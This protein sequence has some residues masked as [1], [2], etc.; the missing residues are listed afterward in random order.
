MD[1]AD[2]KKSETV[3]ILG[4]GKSAYERRVDIDKYLRGDVWTLNTGYRY[5]SHILPHITAWFELHRYDY[6]IKEMAEQQDPKRFETLRDYDVPVFVSETL[7]TITK[8][9]AYPYED[10]FKDLETNVFNGS[11]ALMAMLAIHLGY[12]EICAYGI[13]QLDNQHIDQRGAWAFV[14]GIAHARGIKITGTANLFL[15]VED[16]DEGLRGIRETWGEILV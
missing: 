14:L 3:T 6:L 7:P 4:F 9:I 13:D 8:Q 5:Y 16:N 11:P 12:K 1:I 2:I 15:N 10:V